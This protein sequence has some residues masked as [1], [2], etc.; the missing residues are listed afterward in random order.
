MFLL[1][2]K[3]VFLSILIILTILYVVTSFWISSDVKATIAQVI[4]T[5]DDY[6]PALTPGITKEAF[7]SINIYQRKM[8]DVLSEEGDYDYKVNSI[9]V[10]HYFLGGKVWLK[11]SYHNKTHG[12]GF[13]KEPVTID[14][15]FQS[16]K[17]KIVHAVAEP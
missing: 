4:S 9:W 3:R 17:W 8:R 6:S 16:G 2:K 13:S 10:M 11:H 5:K 14:I 12:F 7:D 1:N 15:K